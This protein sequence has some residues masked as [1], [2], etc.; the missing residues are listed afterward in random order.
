MRRVKQTPRVKGNWE[1]LRGQAMTIQYMTIL[2]DRIK[3]DVEIHGGRKTRALLGEGIRTVGGDDPME[4]VPIGAMYTNGFL[5]A[6]GLELALKAI[7]TRV[8]KDSQHLRTHNLLELYEDVAENKEELAK[9]YESIRK[10]E[11]EDI[12]WPTMYSV[13]NGHKETF[14]KMRYL[15]KSTDPGTIANYLAVQYALAAALTVLEAVETAQE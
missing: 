12:R 15:D 9:E 8:S 2:M 4:T 5:G 10:R 11:G 14:E 6:F 1:L 3:Q 13:V 7:K